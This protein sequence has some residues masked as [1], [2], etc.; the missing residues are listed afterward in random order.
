MA[1]HLNPDSNTS[2]SKAAAASLGPRALGRLADLALWVGF[3]LGLAVVTG[4]ENA[5]G[6]MTYPVW[7]WV[8]SALVPI[9]YEAPP[10]PG[11]VFEC[12]LRWHHVRSCAGPYLPAACEAT[13]GPRDDDGE[14]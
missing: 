13:D 12:A 5:A 14:Q 10:T 9:G 6:E 7:F 2:S 8:A 3:Y 11:H 1:V 4:S